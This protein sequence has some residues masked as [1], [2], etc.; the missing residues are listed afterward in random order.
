MKVYTRPLHK[1]QAS[2]Q[3]WAG[4]GVGAEECPGGVQV[5]SDLFELEIFKFGLASDGATGHTV[6]ALACAP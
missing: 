1:A 4:R 5:N 2:R 3:Q 6:V